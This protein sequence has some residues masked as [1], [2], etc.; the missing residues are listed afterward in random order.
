M[1]YTTITDI[2]QY[3]NPGVICK[4]PPCYSL[5]DCDNAPAKAAWPCKKKKD[6]TSMSYSGASATIVTADSVEL[7]QRSLLRNKAAEAFYGKRIDAKKKFG[8]MGDDAPETMKEL[9]ARIAAGKYVIPAKYEDKYASFSFIEWRDPAVVKDE[10]GYKAAR[11][12][13]QKAFD[14]IDIRLAIL[15]LADA[16]TELEAYVA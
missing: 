6:E 16:L 14:K 15:P 1:S 9:M 5:A 7:K 10:D 11:A 2:E 8:L 4:A 13:L 12:D 3:I